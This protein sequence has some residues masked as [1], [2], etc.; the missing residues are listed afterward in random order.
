MVIR[1]ISLKNIVFNRLYSIIFVLP[2]FL[3]FILYYFPNKY[4]VCLLMN[5]TQLPCP[6]CGMGRAFCYLSHFKFVEAFSYNWLVFLYAFL[7]FLFL[8]INLLPL[9]SKKTIYLYSVKILDKINYIALIVVSVTLVF[10]LVRNVDS[11]N[12]MMIF[13]DIVPE[14]TLLKLLKIKFG[15]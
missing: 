7:F 5:V 12:H 3:G 2:F 6:F 13:K 11:I 4:S 1:K 8:F 15:F 10:G 9:K 14:Y